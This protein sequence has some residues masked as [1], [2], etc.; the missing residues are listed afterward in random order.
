MKP[1]PT[2]ISNIARFTNFW[3]PKRTDFVI[4]PCN[5]AKAIRLPLNDTEPM[6]PPMVAMVRCVMLCSLPPIQRN[7]GDGGRGAAAH[8][9]VQ[10]DHL[11]HIGHG[12]AF[13]ADPGDDAADRDGADHQHQ[14][15]RAKRP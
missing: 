4:K 9:V 12:D 11:R 1:R 2:V 14:I 6:K 3:P 15:E 13:A 7:R 8:A 5:F 10:R